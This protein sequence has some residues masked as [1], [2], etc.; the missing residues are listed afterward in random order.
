[1]YQVFASSGPNNGGIQKKTGAGDR[2]GPVD[3]HRNSVS[4]QN[5]VLLN[6]IKLSAQNQ[7]IVLLQ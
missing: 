7:Y 2:I 4:V 6:I 3:L 1:M 5:Y